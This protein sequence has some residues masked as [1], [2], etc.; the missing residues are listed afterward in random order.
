METAK[1]VFERLGA[2][3][4]VTAFFG[5]LLGD[6]AVNDKIDGIYAAAGIVLVF[7][8]LAVYR[9]FDGKVDD[10]QTPNGGGTQ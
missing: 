5:Y 3:P 1:A 6:L 9:S 4:L 7:V 8:A 2:M 10:D